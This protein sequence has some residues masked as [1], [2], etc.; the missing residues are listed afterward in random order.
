VHTLEM[1]FKWIGICF[2]PLRA[3]S[4]IVVCEGANRITEQRAADK[5]RGAFAE[6][7]AKGCEHRKGRP[8][9]GGLRRRRV[10]AV[11]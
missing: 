8:F 6:S 4:M 2:W 1:H 9:R 10:T 11:R 7:P 5:E 3:H